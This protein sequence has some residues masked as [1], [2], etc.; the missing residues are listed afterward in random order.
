[1][2]KAQ[3]KKAFDPDLYGKI[4]GDLPRIYPVDE[5]NTQVIDGVPVLPDPLGNGA[6]ALK[7]LSRFKFAEGRATGKTIDETTLAPYQLRI[8]LAI[9]GYVDPVSQTRIINN[10]FLSV[11]RKN[12]KS[13]TV[14]LIALCAL[15]SSREPKGEILLAAGSI[16]QAGVMW[17][18]VEGIARTDPTFW[19]SIKSRRF[20]VFEMKNTETDCTLKIVASEAERAHGLSPHLILFDETAFNP[21]E[22]GRRL[23]NALRTGM[24]AR[25]NGLLVQLSTTPDVPLRDG[26]IFKDSVEYDRKVKSGEIDDRRYLGITYFTPPDSDIGD[27]ATWRAANPAVGFSLDINEIREEYTRAVINSGSENEAKAFAALRLNQIPKSALANG[28]LSE[29]TM[30]RMERP[31]TLDDLRGYE[32]VLGIDIGGAEDISAITIMG[33]SGDEYIAYSLGWLSSASYNRHRRAVPL[34]KFVDA[35][36]LTIVD[37][38]IVPPSLIAEEAASIAEYVGATDVAIDPAFASAVVTYL[39]TAGLRV[40]YARQGAMHM[41]APIVVFMSEA[42]AGR[43]SWPDDGFLSWACSNAVLL[44]NSVGQRIT[45][46]TESGQDPNKID[47]IA[48]MMNCWQYFLAVDA[49]QTTPSEANTIEV[50]DVW[51]EPD[52]AWNIK[53]NG[54]DFTGGMMILDDRWSPISPENYFDALGSYILSESPTPERIA[55]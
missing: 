44:T 46:R 6:A 51:T 39:E 32:C 8:L 34:D 12:A 42:Q 25:R 38:D 37:G 52:R 5:T 19:A 45:K 10:M 43:I 13:T 23:L 7:F 4:I 41:A 14:A 29:K 36:V 49:N 11:P 33:R 26:D 54:R 31:I 28:L 9:F 53:N 50:V 24:G 16:K 1:M 18:L 48:A 21:G 55:L 20:P 30:K 27:E 47:P 35:K 22:S 40:S 2:A 3:Q 15:A 17:N